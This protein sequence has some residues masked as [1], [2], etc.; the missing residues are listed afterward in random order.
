MRLIFTLIHRWVGL[1]TAA[2]LF[3]AGSTGA[4]ISWDHELDELLNPHLTNSTTEGPHKSAVELARE[5]EARDPRGQVTYL[6][7][8]ATPGHSL[9]MFVEPRVD[10]ST[11]K[12]YE[13]GYNQVFVDPIT[14]KELGKREWGQAWPITSETLVSFLYKLHYSLHFPTMGGM[15]LMG[16]IAILWMLDCFIGFY[17]TLPPRSSE[18]RTFWQRWKPSWRIKTSASA[19]RITF[20]IH[21][22]F[23][24]WTWG[25]LF[26]LAFTAFSLNLYRE[27]FYPLMSMVSQLTP[28]PYDQRNPTPPNEPIEPRISYAELIEMGK[29]EARRRGWVDNVGAV[30]TARSFGI[31]SV[32]FFDPG[33]DHGSAGVGPP[34]LYFDAIDGRYLGDRQPWGGTAADIF[35]QAQF[36]LHSGRILGLPGRILISVMGIVVAALSV[37]GVIVWARKRSARLASRRRG[38][39]GSAGATGP[40]PAE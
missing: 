7:L 24:L 17:L 26:M 13:L 34:E 37:T 36:P 30:G 8:A 39:R 32:R 4:I 5:V 22:A 29:A 6:P 38:V 10:P 31:L 18:S 3:I 33:G 9:S 28:T 16:G 11:S 21:R 23:G 27:I 25:L 19:Y 14:G 12:L 2:F 35:V 40:F 20:D 1:A 15:W